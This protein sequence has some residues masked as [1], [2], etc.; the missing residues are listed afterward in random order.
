V[1]VLLT[2]PGQPARAAAGAPANSPQF[3]FWYEPWRSD[4]WAKL[5]PANVIIGVPPEAVADIH[6]QGGRALR[7][8]TFYQSTLGTA[9]LHDR[10]DL[11]NVGF[12]TPAGFLPSAFGGKDNYVLCSNSTELHRRV[13]AYV[14]KTVG[15]DG[16]DGLFIDNAYLPPARDEACDAK[17][18]H[19][20]PGSKGGPAYIDLLAEVRAAVKKRNAAAILFVNSGNPRDADNLTSGK[21]S[22][23]DMSDYV[24]WESYAYSSLLGGAHDRR[25]NTIVESMTVASSSHANKVVALAY[26]RTFPEALFSF[27]VARAFGFPYAA[28]LGERDYQR[29]HEGGHFGIFLQDLPSMIGPPES[30][31]RR[32]NDL[33]VLQRRFH[34]GVIVVNTGAESWSLKAPQS[35]VLYSPAGRSEIRAGAK[36]AVAPATAVVL[37]FH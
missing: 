6:A 19:R 26:P 34:N 35:A 15:Q 37:S 32:D 22:L 1:L 23:W 4:S 14:E 8:A 10:A 33:R 28:N 20:T 3:A 11:A 30:P 27:A 18:A 36:V 24:L 13:L 9:F 2:R 5:Q 21:N 7:Y 17:H 25:H 29:E 31:L 16:Y 12:H